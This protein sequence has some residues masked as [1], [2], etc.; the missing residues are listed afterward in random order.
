MIDLE[1]SDTKKHEKEVKRIWKEYLDNLASLPKDPEAQKAAVGP[2]SMKNEDYLADLLVAMGRC[3]GY[4]FDRVYIKKGIYAPEGHSRDQ[5][6]LQAIRQLVLR[7]LSGQS[8]LATRTA[9]VPAS[10]KDAEYGERF[11]S[12]LL[13]VVEGQQPLAIKPPPQPEVTPLVIPNKASP[14]VES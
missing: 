14:R 7:L 4:R 13:G 9:L 1:F 3:L 6:E 2:W 12:A 11:R 8:A 5:M 10:E